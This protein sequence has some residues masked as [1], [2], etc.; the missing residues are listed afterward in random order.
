[1]KIGVYKDVRKLFSQGK[2]I[3]EIRENLKKKGHSY[4]EVSLALEHYFQD[5]KTDYDDKLISYI[6]SQY[7][8]GKPLDS[9]CDILV[10]KGHKPVEVHKALVRIDTRDS[11][12]IGSLFGEMGKYVTY[13]SIL[14]LFCVL[15]AI[16]V[17]IVFFFGVLIIGLQLA[18]SSWHEV[19]DKSKWK[20][21]IE[22]N[23]VLGLTVS[24]GYFMYASGGRGGML[25]PRFWVMHPS[26]SQFMLFILFS[27][28]LLWFK[29]T[30]SFLI[31]LVFSGLSVIS[32]AFFEKKIK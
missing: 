27:F 14:M 2:T 22:V 16:F 28:T 30:T 7:K 10:K 20:V 6:E 17:D 4:D 3:V 31:G 12:H 21:E 18:M 9:I 23:P 5:E 19:K 32:G 13:Q 26:V 15:C 11:L 25:I 1:M 8:K 29:G 24:K